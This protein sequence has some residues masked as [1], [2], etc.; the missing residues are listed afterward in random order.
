MS[1]PFI[2]EIRMAG[3]NYA[4]VG[5]A[6]CNGQL[7]PIANYNALFAL[8]GTTYGG[9]GQNTF[10]LPDLQGRTVYGQGSLAGTTYTMGETLGTE[11]VT[12]LSTQLPAHTHVAASVAGPAVPNPSTSP[13]DKLP[14]SQPNATDPPYDVAPANTTMNATAIVST[15]GNQPHTNIQPVLAINFIIALEGVF[16][17]RN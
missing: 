7:L 14:S 3:F 4:P 16:P 5:F 11:T 17:S 1:N 8:I 15:G 9:D 10:G 2:G 12:L 6:F 13:A